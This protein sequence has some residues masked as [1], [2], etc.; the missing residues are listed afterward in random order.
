MEER[1]EIQDRVNEIPEIEER[2]VF[3]IMPRLPLPR[4]QVGLRM[5]REVLREQEEERVEPPMPEI[6]C[7]ICYV[8]SRNYCEEDCGHSFCL[9]CLKGYLRENLRSGNYIIKCPEYECTEQISL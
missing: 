5:R 2:R 1:L 3:P 8:L 4:L 9:E 7:N 6:L